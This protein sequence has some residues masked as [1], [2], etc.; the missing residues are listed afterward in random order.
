MPADQSPKQDP[1]ILRPMPLVTARAFYFTGEDHLRV[2]VFNGATGVILAVR[3]RF[4]RDAGRVEVF[5]EKITPAT[6]RTLS[7]ANFPRGE[8]YLIDLEVFATAGTPRKGDCFVIVLVVRGLTGAVVALSK[9]TSGYVTDTTP[10][11]WPSDPATMS[12]DGRGRIRVVTGADPAAGAEPSETV[13]TN[14]R[15]RLLSWTATL[16][17]AVAV[18]NREPELVFDDGANVFMRAPSGQNQL[19]SLTRIYSVYP[20]AN[21]FTIATDPT[22]TIP[23]PDVY[24]MGGFRVRTI[25]GG[26]QAADDW[27][28]PQMLIEEWIED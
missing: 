4:L 14:A 25:T 22:I 15:W 19:A 8:G 13:P 5:D 26:L 28:A 20:F 2:T 17:T 9:V 27:G 11:T 18:A 21:R 3:G 23:I 6:D 7:A 16:V 1:T 24:L 10:L 12:P